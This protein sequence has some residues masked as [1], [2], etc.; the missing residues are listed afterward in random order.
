M[1]STACMRVTLCRSTWRTTATVPRT[2][3]GQQRHL[4]VSVP[5]TQRPIETWQEIRDLLTPEEQEALAAAFDLD[6][7]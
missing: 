1:D 2:L 5:W 7:P 6:R 4:V 3:D